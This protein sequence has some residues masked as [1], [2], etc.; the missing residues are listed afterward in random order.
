MIPADIITGFL[1][2]GKTTLLKHVLSH[3]LRDRKVAVIVNDMAD[4]G[5]DGKVIQGLDVDKMVELSNG[6]VCCSISYRFAA[7][8]QEIIDTVRPD[9][10][11]IET[12]GVSEPLPLVEELRTTGVRTDAI[13]TV[14]DSAN[15]SRALKES[16]VTALQIATADF[17]VLNKIDLVSPTD[18]QRARKQVTRLNKRATLFPTAHATVPSELLF[19]TAPKAYRDRARTDVSAPHDGGIAA[20]TYQKPVR[21]NR[22]WFERFLRRLPREI[23]RSKGVVHLSDAEGLSLFNYT[24][25]R[26]DI[27]SIHLA[28]QASIPTQA[29][30]IGKEIERLRPSILA[31]LEACE[32]GAPRPFWSSLSGLI[33]RKA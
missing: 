14:V 1:G 17:L 7:A 4:L 26:F 6:C 20:F 5:I 18:L 24:C 27:E 9:L 2:S 16:A 15:L 12:S 13:I 30:F 8:V 32:E 19:A 3:G 29:V 22:R 28:D 31:E 10:L 33:A 21:L 25:G 23:I 11:I